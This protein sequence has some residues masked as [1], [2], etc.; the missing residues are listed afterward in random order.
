MGLPLRTIAQLSGNMPCDL[1]ATSGI[2][3]GESIV[4][5]LLVG[6]S[7]VQIVSAFYRGGVE[8][9]GGMLAEVGAWM[10]RHEVASIDRFRGRMRQ[11]AWPDGAAYD[12]VQ[13]MRR[14][15]ESKAT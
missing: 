5:M 13:F 9:I 14:T 7:A 8:L 3:D 12:R 15:L 2:A 4:K 11:E 10:S 1:C 6:A